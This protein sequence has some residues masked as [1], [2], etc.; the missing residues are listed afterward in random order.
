LT[1][2][3]DRLSGLGRQVASGG[4]Q[5]LGSVIALALA[6][7]LLSSVL[8]GATSRY[9]ITLRDG[10]AVLA[11]DLPARQGTVYVFHGYPDGRW[12]GIPAEQVLEIVA[13]SEPATPA[14]KAE[15]AR[16]GGASSSPGAS[17]PRAVP[18]SVPAPPVA[19]APAAGQDPAAQLAAAAAA[20]RPKSGVSLDDAVRLT[21]EYAPAVALARETANQN[22][23]ILQT[24]TGQF[25]SQAIVLPSYAHNIGV[26]LHADILAETQ[27][28]ELFSVPAEA[29][30]QLSQNLQ[31]SLDSGNAGPVVGP[32]PNITITS[33]ANGTI[34][35]PC[36]DPSS[37]RGQH[38]QSLQDILNG[39][40]ANDENVQN[41]IGAD[42]IQK[43]LNGAYT[44]L[45][46]TFIDSANQAVAQLDGVLTDLGPL[47]RSASID[48]LSLGMQYDL[49]F[50]N[51]LVAGPLVVL[52]GIQNNFTGKSL[53]PLFGGRAIPTIYSTI[54]GLTFS[55]PLA[56]GS[57]TTAVTAP[58]VA[59]RFNF[60][61]SLES[62][63]QTGSQ[64]ALNSV[65]A[66]WNLVGAQQ[67]LA[68][69]D[70]SRASQARIA[71]LSQALVA[72]D[73]MAPAEMDLVRARVADVDAAV[74]QARVALVAARV[75]LAQ[76]MGL[77]ID[78]LDGAAPATD[79]F[80]DPEENDR[81]EA[82][83]LDDL[84]QKALR[85]RSDLKALG[86]VAS[87]SEVLEKAARINLRPG[88]DL[89]LQA[90]FRSF[91]ENSPPGGS[92]PS[93][94]QNAFYTGGYRNAFNSRFTGPN[95]IVGLKLQLPFANNVQRGLLAQ[96]ES[97]R[98]QS[99]VR[100]GD[101]ARVIRAQILQVLKD[102]QMS[103]REVGIRK[104]AAEQFVL[105]IDAAFARYR[106]GEMSLLD[107]IVTE[108]DQTQS[109]LDLV[110]ARQAYAS[111][112]AQ[113]RFQTGSLVR[114]TKT[115]D[116]VVFGS[117][118]PYGFRFDQDA[119][120]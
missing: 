114:Y 62:L 6:T 71:E 106:A 98:Q 87:A 61:S 47:P 18:A 29:L 35:Q 108:R 33:Q 15:G 80:P 97:T 7:V 79:P 94:F 2:R 91:W 100:E 19:P 31:Q 107:A 89:S 54:I 109:L 43:S 59:A 27:K 84:S 99:V 58:E 85:D 56:R 42:N 9:R 14:P 88:L 101:L 81:L 119:N 3:L 103:A 95:V 67:R 120:P 44:S 24:A 77:T 49:S 63:A 4:A 45:F 69:L 53:D 23:G 65:L 38:A 102:V 82:L 115:K 78:D 32:C 117:V 36:L 41:R 83:S 34:S 92:P 111:S 86:S 68:I 73:E 52:Q 1:P 113:L 76:A 11:E 112:V 48:T 66:Y 51:G 50:R 21:L 13:I 25:D 118:E 57:G 12:T 96:A 93:D 72:A 105:T 116:N 26:L 40:S 30:Q 8:L 75:A 20:A 110:L 70:H 5:R 55:M 17:A 22:R 37:E 10:T 60:E 28:R 90:D 46:Q 64:S 104:V 74:A 39:I 16:P